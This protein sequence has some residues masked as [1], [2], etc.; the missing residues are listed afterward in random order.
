MEL[1]ALRLFVVLAD[2][3]HFGRAARRA[4][5]TQSVLSLQIQRL[6]DVVGAELFKRST[7]NVR[8]TEVGA[9]LRDQAEGALRR[10][11]EA[12]AAAR[13]RATGTGRILRMGLTSAVLVSNVMGHIARF[14]MAHP[15]I[16][17]TMRE[18]GTLDQEIAL[19]NG[20]LDVGILH[21]PVANKALQKH[22]LST[23]RLLASFNPAFF[24]PP[25]QPGWRDLLDHPVVFYQRRRAPTYFA[26]LIGRAD[27]AGAALNVVAEAESFFAAAAMAQAGLGVAL[28]PRCIRDMNAALASRDL[29][30]GDDFTLETAIAF[31]P[32]VSTDPAV[33]ACSHSLL[34]A[35]QR[36]NPSA[37]S[38]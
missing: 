4:G 9:V 37:Q 29:P 34:G 36:P 20:D 19:A 24:Q 11:D 16:R 21:P 32:D 8:L 27:A 3:L 25:D 12:L 13:A 38:G 26:D 28:L 33:L 10:C 18:M 14:R 31:H 15:N 22:R 5:V 2:E 35:G 17:V 6:E 1:K 7:R 23:E 30:P